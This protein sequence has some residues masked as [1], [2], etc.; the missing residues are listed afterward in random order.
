MSSSHPTS[1]NNYTD[2]YHITNLD[3]PSRKR[4]ATGAALHDDFKRQNTYIGQNVDPRA[5]YSDAADVHQQQ[6]SHEYYQQH[7]RPDQGHTPPLDVHQEQKKY[8]ELERTPLENTAQPPCTVFFTP[9]SPA[10]I[11]LNGSSSVPSYESYQN[12]LSFYRHYQ[13]VP[14]RHPVAA[15]PVQM[16]TPPMVDHLPGG[17][18]YR[19][20]TPT[21]AVDTTGYPRE[22]ND[23]PEY[24]VER[25][26]AQ[27]RHRKPGGDDYPTFRH[28]ESDGNEEV[29]LV[30]GRLPIVS[31]RT[32]CTLTANELRRR[33]GAPEYMNL[34]TIYCFLRK[35]KT[36]ASIEAIKD[37]LITY[38]IQFSEFRQRET[39]RFSGFLEEDA[40]GLAQDLRQLHKRYFDVQAVAQQMVFNLLAKGHSPVQCHEMLKKTSVVLQHI[41]S[42]LSARQPAVANRVEKLKGNDCDLPYHIFNLSTH[43]FGHIN[44]LDHYNE[45]L[46]IVQKAERL[47]EQLSHN[48][49]MPPIELWRDGE[50]PFELLSDHETQHMIAVQFFRLLQ[51]LP[52]AARTQELARFTFTETGQKM[53]AMLGTVISD[54]SGR[55]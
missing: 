14:A 2:S 53:L 37:L 5:F 20:P 39:T 28:T 42:S 27:R 18:D 19:R 23:A 48:I 44:S 4:Q 21:D 22:H 26:S 25:F 12:D 36:K 8:T 51:R 55:S 52:K 50:K 46:V 40:I 24:I 35:S 11:S 41:T 33:V 1:S 6:S 29:T 54:M 16:R 7:Q 9:E 17:S 49:P 15:A 38:R 45:Q 34:S 10:D 30:D 32:K 43:G 31:A 3:Q 13:D 47:A